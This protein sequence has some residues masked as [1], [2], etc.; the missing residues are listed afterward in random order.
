MP[1]RGQNLH[2]RGYAPC[3][4]TSRVFG[5]GDP[6]TACSSMECQLAV[7]EDAAKA[8]KGLV[9]VL[10]TAATPQ[11]PGGLSGWPRTHRK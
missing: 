3:W 10:R 11:S 5:L 8:W 6:L 1:G 7:L 2:S 9:V 4:I